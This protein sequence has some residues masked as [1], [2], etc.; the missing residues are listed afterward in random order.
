M[1]SGVD[2]LAFLELE[3]IDGDIYRG[4]PGVWPPDRPRI[5]GGEVA[6]QALRAAAHTVPA[7]RLPHSLHG[8][9]LRQGDPKLPVIYSVDRD[10]DGRSFS[11]RR[12]AAMQHGEVIW[13]MACS[14]AEPVDGPEF[15]RPM[16]PGMAG[17]DESAPIDHVW[18][19]MIEVRVPPPPD[20]RPTRPEGL[21][22]CW[23]KVITP[24]PDDPILHACLLAFTSDVSS[25]FADLMMDGVPTFGPSLDHALWFHGPV[26]A[27][28]W[29]L[30]ESE[31]MKVGSHRGLYRGAAYDPAGRLVAML[32][33]EML[34][35][36]T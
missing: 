7:G 21:D 19:P 24:V 10:R 13:D 11:A 29:V 34:L 15:G 1:T 27:D 2:F 36:P 6:A 18:C 3:P 30:Y 23:T 14:F 26:R 12:V 28:D 25:G 17:P 31:P 35:R 33:Q 8:Y 22:R 5:F 32:A 4:W 20:G 16:T 9:F